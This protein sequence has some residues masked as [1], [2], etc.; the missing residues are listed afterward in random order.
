VG[1]VVGWATWSGEGEV[2]N[3]AT[4]PVVGRDVRPAQTDEA[5]QVGGSGGTTCQ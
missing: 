2:G 1:G 3:E 4:T 5:E